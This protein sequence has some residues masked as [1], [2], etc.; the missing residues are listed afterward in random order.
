LT[1]ALVHHL[2]RIDLM[3]CRSFLTELIEG[4]TVRAGIP[5]KPPLGM[6]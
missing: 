3:V 4:E 2:L 5:S 1:L 6:V